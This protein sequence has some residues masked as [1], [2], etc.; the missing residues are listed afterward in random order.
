MAL[1]GLNLKL[2]RAVPDTEHGLD[3]IPRSRYRGNVPVF[4]CGWDA[5]NAFEVSHLDLH[6]TPVQKRLRLMVPANS[7]NILESKSLKLYLNAWNNTCFDPDAFAQRL[8]VDFNAA[9]GS[10][11]SLCFEAPSDPWSQPSPEYWGTSLDAWATGVEAQ[12]DVA[13]LAKGDYSGHQVWTSHLFRSR[14]PVT[15]QPDWA[16]IRVEMQA[17]AVSP[18]HLLRYL[19]S[20]RNHQAFHEACC[21]QICADLCTAYQPDALQVTCY[22]SRRG[23]I[24]I[25]PI[26]WYPEP[27]Q[28]YQPFF[29]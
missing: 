26:R 15:G 3:A 2:G 5:W 25:Q 17:S 18:Q 24:D 16:T 10:E 27:M 7:L 22:F 9:T 23:G 20:Y 28:P 11:V 6:G 12:P 21:E 14:C 13:L 8:Q 29:R 1:D 4:N 19:V